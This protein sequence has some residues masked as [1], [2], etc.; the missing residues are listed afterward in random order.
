MGDIATVKLKSEEHDAGRKGNFPIKLII[1]SVQITCGLNDTYPPDELPFLFLSPGGMRIEAMSAFI[2][3]NW[4]VELLCFDCLKGV[5]DISNNR[6]SVR[7]FGMGILGVEHRIVALVDRDK[8]DI[9]A[10]E[11]PPFGWLRDEGL[12]S[13]LGL[14]GVPLFDGLFFLL[15]HR[16]R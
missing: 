15:R 6:P 14:G 5:V 11:L 10:A 1:L 8:A 9:L 12:P 4:F 16:C 2:T 3:L 13:L 7:F